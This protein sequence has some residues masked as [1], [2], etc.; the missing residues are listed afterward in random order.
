MPSKLPAEASLLALD[1]HML[2]QIADLSVLLTW[3]ARRLTLTA[4]Q[5]SVKSPQVAHMSSQLPESATMPGSE[6]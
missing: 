1:I 4:S 5:V 2:A 3:I 6:L